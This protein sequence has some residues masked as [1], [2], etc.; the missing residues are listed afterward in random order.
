MARPKKDVKALKA[1]IV[2]FRL[3]ADKYLELT[4]NADSLGLTVPQFIRKK[5]SGSVLAK[6]R[7]SPIDRKVYVE[8]SRIGNN[9]NQLTR[10]RYLGMRNPIHL[11]EQLNEM[12]LLI[13][14]LKSK[15]VY[16]ASKAD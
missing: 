2:S 4:K 1:I 12:K 3:N 7:Y 6:M 16:D 5:I 15:I 14:D 8:L 13:D 9:I 10:Q 11:D